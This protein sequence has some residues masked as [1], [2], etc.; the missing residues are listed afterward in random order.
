[1]RIILAPS[2]IEG[3]AVDIGGQPDAEAL[4]CQGQGK[5][6]DLSMELRRG[7]ALLEGNGQSTFFRFL[8]CLGGAFE[9]LLVLDLGD[10]PPPWCVVGR[11]DVEC[12]QRAV[13]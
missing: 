5:K 2:E 6:E 12:N 13:S 3:I 9:A 7:C 1:M 8:A 4:A 11:E 10:T